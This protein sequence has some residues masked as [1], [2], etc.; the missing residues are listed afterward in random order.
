MMSVVFAL[1]TL[2]HYFFTD[3]FHSIIFPFISNTAQQRMNELVAIGYYP[4]LGLSQP[5]M[6]AAPIVIGIG[7][8]LSSIELKNNSKIR[9]DYILLF[10]FIISL[11]MIGKR[12]ILI[13]VV[14]AALFTYYIAGSLKDKFKRVVKLV[15]GFLL[16]LF[17]FFIGFN[18]FDSVPFLSR[19]VE[20]INGLIN[21]ED[22]TSGRLVL[23]ERAWEIFKENPIFGIGWGQFLVVTSGKLLSRDL[24]VHNVYLQ[25]L[26]ETGLVGFI[27]I[28][29]PFLYVYYRTFKIVKK[30]VEYK[31][32]SSL[33][34]KGIIFSFYYQTFF[35]LY[36]L[37]ENPFYNIVYMMMYFFS[38]S[39]VN[40]FIIY[41][42]LLSRKFKEN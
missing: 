8:I 36:C 6:A 17:L 11:I 38:I 24:S 31:F 19:T 5:S 13:W 2:F 7:A 15:I 12:S 27:L 20:T 42:N 29:I 3:V 30:M 32:N 37:T 35:L 14:F 23:Y 39:I 25:L 21:G 40:S 4:G 28:M 26:S 16:I 33:W 18:Y 10:I 22:V 9:V 1:T 41:K 34:K